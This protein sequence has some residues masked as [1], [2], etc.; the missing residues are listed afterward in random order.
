VTPKREPE[1]DR[2]GWLVAAAI[3]GV[4]G[5]AGAAGWIVFGMEVGLPVLL[6]GAFF[7]LGAIR[8]GADPRGEEEDLWPDDQRD[9]RSVLHPGR[10]ASEGYAQAVQRLHDRRPM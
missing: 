1:P 10:G 7:A 6:V 5:V 8:G 2:N 3:A 4:V 9:E